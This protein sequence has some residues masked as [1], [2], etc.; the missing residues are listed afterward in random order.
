MKKENRPPAPR[1]I[2]WP[3]GPDATYQGPLT[4]PEGSCTGLPVNPME[5]PR[6]G[7]DVHES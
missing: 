1:E 2:F 3:V 4:D 6:K 5:R 7:A